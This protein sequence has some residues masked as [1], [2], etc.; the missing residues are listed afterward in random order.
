M[1]Q[2]E[3]NSINLS[4]ASITPKYLS[5]ISEEL[6][7]A[8]FWIKRL[9]LSYNTLNFTG[10]PADIE[11]SKKFV[12]DMCLFLDLTDLLN[13]VD[14][15]GMNFDS[16]NLIKVCEKMAVCPN[17]MAIHLNDYQLLDSRNEDLLREIFSIFKL[18]ENESICRGKQVMKDL[19]NDK[20][21]K[22]MLVQSREKEQE[23]QAEQKEPD[24]VEMFKLSLK[25]NIMKELQKKELQMHN[26]LNIEKLQSKKKGLVMI[27]AIQQRNKLMLETIAR[28]E[29]HYKMDSKLGGQNEQEKE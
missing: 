24:L 17:L 11:H 15:S 26:E 18:E 1:Y 21:I 12:K 19:N 10:N 22:E 16:H 6:K 7:N 9:D 20:E 2:G 8:P 27:Q 25:M 4:H 29:R 23:E 3:L 14:L 13:H 5:M 28:T